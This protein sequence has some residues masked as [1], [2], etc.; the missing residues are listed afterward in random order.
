MGNKTKD[1]QFKKKFKYDKNK[2]KTE[3][4]MLVRYTSSPNEIGI[5]NITKE[6]QDGED[7]KKLCQ[8]P[9]RAILV[10]AGTEDIKK[11]CMAH[12]GEMDLTF[13]LKRIQFKT[14]LDR[15]RFLHVSKFLPA[16]IERMVAILESGKDTEKIVTEEQLEEIRKEFD[17]VRKWLSESGD[18]IS[19]EL[20]SAFDRYLSTQLN[21]IKIKKV[22]SGFPK[23]ADLIGSI[24]CRQEVLRQD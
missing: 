9:N 24:V 5:Y 7:F 19:P 16:H 11:W 12:A 22:L 21:G 8:D 15:R 2:Q 3:T 17:N 20:A 23:F 18:L 1:I 10:T 6:L 14:D 13:T 4:Y